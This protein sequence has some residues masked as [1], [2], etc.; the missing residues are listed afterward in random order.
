MTISESRHPLVARRPPPPPVASARSP[1]RAAAR[2]DLLD[3]AELAEERR[4]PG[5]GSLD[6]CPACGQADPPVT[7]LG[8]V[9]G[10][11]VTDCCE[12]GRDGAHRRF[13]A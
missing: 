9:T 2:L 11:T 3:E 5:I 10:A 13:R 12:K 8:D 1:K 7:T 4:E 6:A